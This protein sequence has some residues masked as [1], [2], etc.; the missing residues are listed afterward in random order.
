MRLVEDVTSEA[1]VADNYQAGDTA[2]VDM[3]ASG[4]PFVTCHRKPNFYDYGICLF[5]AT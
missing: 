5:V 1:F 2:L 3:D 4:Y